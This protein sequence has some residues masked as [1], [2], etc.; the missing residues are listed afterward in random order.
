[1][2]IVSEL[3]ERVNRIPFTSPATIAFD[4]L[5]LKQMY[6][7]LWYAQRQHHEIVNAIEFREGARAEALLREHVNTQK[8]SMNLRRPQPEVRASEEA[9]RS[10]RKSA[11]RAPA[12]RAAGPDR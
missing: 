6:D 10:R 11:A 9:V 8:H 1:M 12:A 2:S 5:N 4:R 3:L 7:D